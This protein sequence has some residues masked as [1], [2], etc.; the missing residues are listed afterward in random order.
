MNEISKGAQLRNE[1]SYLR[2]IAGTAKN[3]ITRK[4]LLKLAEEYDRMSLNPVT[5]Y[6]KQLPRHRV[7]F[8]T[9][10]IPA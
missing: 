9:D 7:N 6:P 1:A 5:I 3:E 2:A 10:V 8:K 4:T